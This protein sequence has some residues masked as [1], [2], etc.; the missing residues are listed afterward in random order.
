MD[1]RFDPDRIL[2]IIRV[3]HLDEESLSAVSDDAFGLAASGVDLED[4]EP[5]RGGDAAMDPAPLQDSL[6]RSQR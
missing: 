1:L 5:E 2:L 6:T 3:D 4:R